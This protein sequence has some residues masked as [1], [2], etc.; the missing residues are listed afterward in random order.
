SVKEKITRTLYAHL[1]P[2]YLCAIL[3]I[4]LIVTFF[5]YTRFSAYH[6]FVILPFMLLLLFPVSQG[7]IALMNWFL[8]LLLTPVPL[9]KMDYSE[10]VPGDRSTIVVIPTVLSGLADV[11]KLV[12]SLEIRYLGNRDDNLF[13]ALLTD[14]RNAPTEELPEDEELVNLLAAEIEGLNE[15]YQSDKPG[16][17]F[18][19]HRSRT[20]NAGEGAWMGYERK[21]G[22]LEAFS[23]YLSDHRNNRFSRIVGRQDLLADIKYVITLDTDTQLPRNSARSLIGAITHPL[24]RPMSDPKTGVIKE[25]YG[26]LQPRVAL[27][28]SESG[29]S[30]FAS[31]F[32]GEQGIDPYTRAVSDLYQDAFHEGSFIGKG[33]YDLGEFSRSIK[34]R[35]PENLILSHDLLEGCYA[36]SGLV[37]DVQVFEEHPISYLA[38][39]RRRHRWIRGDWQIIPW[40]FPRVTDNSSKKQRNPLSLL[41]RWK[42]FDNLR[43]R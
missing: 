35:F 15:R 4:T 21:R 19:M 27:S 10:G 23:L 41:S 20:W 43:R 32:G 17:F 5:G 40:L 26:I 33:I 14:L 36:R 6:G 22:I 18:L 38:D 8:P 25:G 42:I 12:H 11:T 13:F 7:V 37:S 9:P 29:I 2:Q 16:T 1:L 28:L 34:G 39:I 24:S 30:R 31:L 3:V